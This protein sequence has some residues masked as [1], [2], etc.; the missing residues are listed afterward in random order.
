MKCPKPE[1]ADGEVLK[2]IVNPSRVYSDTTCVLFQC[3]ISSSQ[4]CAARHARHHASKILWSTFHA[5][6][7]DDRSGS[8][9]STQKESPDKTIEH[10][11]IEEGQ[12]GSSQ[13]ADAHA[14]R[15]CSTAPQNLTQNPSAEVFKVIA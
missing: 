9:A 11:R 10:Y 6:D 15:V 4:A 5:H 14:K 13:H 3:V 1:A 2:H 8:I 12:L 7:V